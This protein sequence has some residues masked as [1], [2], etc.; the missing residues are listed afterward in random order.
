M[1]TNALPFT[2]SRAS[3]VLSRLNSRILTIDGAMGT[4]IQRHRL[5]EEDYRGERFKDW[6]C[7]IKGNNDLL[8]ITRPDVIEGVHRAFLE[9]GADIIETNTFNAQAMSQGDYDMQSVVRDINLAAAAVARG[10]ADE[11]TALTPDKPRLVAGAIGPMNRALSLS[12]NVNDPAFRSVSYQE[13]LAAYREQVEALLDGGID[14]FLVETIFDT[15]NAKAALHAIDEV[16]NERG[17]RLPVFVSVTITD[18]SGRTLS[19]QTLEAFWYSI[20]HARPFAVGLNC[21]LGGEQMRPY[22]QE[23]ARLADCYTLLYPN[24]GLP[25]AFG[26][27]D[28]LPDDTGR[29]LQDYANEG[30]LNIVG[31]CCG[32]TPEH[33]AAIHRHV[34][35]LKPRVPSVRQ[36]LSRY[37]GLEPLVV[38]PESNFVMVGER[39]N[40][41]GSKRFARLIKS[42]DFDE[43]LTIA[44]QQVENG[45]NVI[46]INMDEGMLDS[47]AAMSHFLRLIAS[48]PDI[49]RVPIMIDSSKFD[50]I[51]EGLRWVQ[52][53]AIVNSI[54]L[55]EGEESFLKQARIVRQY[56]AAVVVMAFD[57]TGQA[58]D[59]AQRLQIMDRAYRLLTEVVGFPPEDIIYD[60]NILAI[61][62]GIEEH[63]DY[64]VAFIEATRQI[65]Q[66]FPAI[67]ISGGVSNLSFSFRGNDRVREA[68]H[69]VFLY[70]ATRAGMDMGIVNAG[71]LEIYEQI[72]AD[73]LLHIED[74]VLNRRPD[75]TER[76]ITFA[77]SVKGGG[78]EVVRDM[79]WREASVEERLKHALVV[80][81][82]EFI[83][84]DT[85]EAR[86]KYAR[87]LQVIEGPLMD[88]MSVVGDLFGQGKM[89]L[90]QVVKSARAMKKAVAW[91]LP[92]MEAEKLAAEAAGEHVEARGKILLAT[93]KGD[94]HD[95]GKNI[96][97]V[98]LACNNYDIIDMGVMVP[99]DKIIAAAKEQGV[100]AVGLSG[101]ITPSL[102]EMVSVAREM[103]RQGL[104]IP[105]LIGGATTSRRHTSVKIAKE[106][107]HPVVHVLDASRAVGVVGALLSEE[108][109]E[110][111]VAQNLRHQD[112]DRERY[113]QRS[114]TRLLTMDQARANALPTDWATYVPPRPEFT[115]ARTIDVPIAELIPWIDWSP[116]FSTW[117]LKGSYPRILKH[118]TMGAAAQELFDHA[119]RMLQQ[120]VEAGTL[121]ARGVYGFFPAAADGDD[122]LLY[123]DESRS[124]VLERMCMLRQQKVKAG[125]E[126][127]NL[128]LA[129]YV[130]PAATGVPDWMGMFA[131]TAGLGLDEIVAAFDAAHDDYNSIMAKALAD[132]LAEAFAEYL[133]ARVR[134]EWAYGR[135]EALPIDEVLQEKYRG[136]RP[137]P[138][139]PA[140]PDHTEKAK[141]FDL[142]RARQEV[143]MELTESFAMTPTAAVSGY[144][145][146]HEQAHYFTIGPIAADQVESYA[147]RK[148]MRIDAVEKWLGQNLSYDP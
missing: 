37:S 135:D 21:A 12:P 6:H 4:M 5:S 43:A 103:K 35:G 88:G 40:V 75:A 130:A 106:Y 30:W 70:H 38:R 104:S 134:R 112:E 25:N 85:E 31:G 98:V 16:Q 102:D 15:L 91:L 74:V 115:G 32:T 99:T 117:E 113:S 57:E 123:T 1:N 51:E 84:E 54:S 45:A 114:T 71:Q 41:T 125:E 68:M 96:V 120:L 62:T 50:V 27:Y 105:L 17:V 129:D 81:N 22:I 52:G 145:F 121:R 95:I 46:D 53:K 10:V 14:L 23:L 29:I 133:H 59:V 42:G 65:K 116:F 111:F 136:I 139:Y 89:F 44:R 19:G 33:I 128:C 61:G 47:R 126:Q 147:K 90:P 58:V 7:D 97:G 28:E 87:P 141:L 39:T 69:S 49:S 94:V 148:S 132:R 140:C 26:E 11:F 122:V 60:P 72:P 124:T 144:Y 73:L 100:S 78:R 63:N 83:D 86:L 24:A 119:Q 13:V 34:Q 93:V 36:T 18:A 2:S 109:R 137:A 64:A 110:D 56:G 80:G 67:R 3:L 131:V 9:A 138:G 118:P 55:K 108:M 92:Y 143:G 8:S 79:S 48:E 76:L 146:S 82:I 142:L 107:D 20:E 101:L 66:R 77:E 127:A